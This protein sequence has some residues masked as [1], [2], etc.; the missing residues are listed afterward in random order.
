MH[1]QFLACLLQINQDVSPVFSSANDADDERA[2]S[3]PKRVKISQA[4]R[5]LTNDQAFVSAPTDPMAFAD[6]GE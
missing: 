1:V 6:F 4:K 3:A 2:M 5:Q